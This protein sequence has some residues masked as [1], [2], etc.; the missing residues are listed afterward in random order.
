MAAANDLTLINAILLSNRLRRMWAAPTRLDEI[1][2]ELQSTFSYTSTF[3]LDRHLDLSLQSVTAIS[4]F[5]LSRLGDVISAR[6]FDFDFDFDFPG[7]V[8]KGKKEIEYY[9]IIYFQITCLS[10]KLNMSLLL[11]SYFKDI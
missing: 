8:L 5:N 7:M 2:N 4:H 3:H 1:T 10:Q 9:D 6:D 11:L